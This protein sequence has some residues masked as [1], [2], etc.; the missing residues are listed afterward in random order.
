VHVAIATMEWLPE[1]YRDDEIL[2]DALRAH[3]AQVG[4]VPWGDRGADWGA[5]DAVVIRSTWDYARRRDEFLAWADA[6]GDRLHNPPALVRW[7]TDKRYLA[8]L[9]AAGYAVIETTY[10]DPGEPAPPLLGEVVVKPTVSAG[11]RDTGRFGP[12]SHHLAMELIGA[13][14]AGGRTAM[15][16]PYLESIDYAGETA[17]VFVDGRPSHGLRKRAVLTSE[18]VA[19]TRDDR[20]G[21]A[22][23]MYD[24][25]LV[26][27]ADPEDDELAVASAVIEE[28][29]RRFSAPPLYA[30]IDLARDRGGVPVV[31]EVEA[32]EPSLYLNLVPGAAERLA[33]AIT[34]RVARDRST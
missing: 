34:A 24:P 30:R 21:A 22:E 6:V 31:L 11:G 19:P 2:T 28:L 3:G 20:I 27:R 32:V 17:I 18:G 16:Q 8:D 1:E 13:I 7:N 15:V 26:T 23:A 4:A 9:A 12:G 5:Y 33:D 25:E 29:A 14:G 10:V